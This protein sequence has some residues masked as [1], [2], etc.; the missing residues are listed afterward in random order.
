M[1][2]LILVLMVVGQ[3]ALLAVTDH[4]NFSENAAVITMT[5]IYP[6]IVIGGGWLLNH[7]LFHQS[8]PLVSKWRFQCWPILY[9]ILAD[10]LIY[11]FSW[12]AQT[13]F[14]SSFT[15]MSNWW[16]QFTM[17]VI[18]APLV[19]EYVFRGYIFGALDSIF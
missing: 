17:T 5:I 2:I 3:I 16:L 13:G 4:L 8:L 10:V 15:T 1:I 19:E 9:A 14:H 12:V 7:F 6:I 11:L 18:S